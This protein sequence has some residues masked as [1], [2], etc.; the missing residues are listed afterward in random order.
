[1]YA[2]NLVRSRDKVGAIFIYFFIYFK[3]GNTYNEHDKISEMYK[4]SKITVWLQESVAGLMP[5]TPVQCEYYTMN[6]KIVT[7]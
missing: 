4:N 3:I 2:R 6:L 1:V 5:L 7:R